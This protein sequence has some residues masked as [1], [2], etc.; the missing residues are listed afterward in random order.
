V[1]CNIGAIATDNIGNC[2]R[3]HKQLQQTTCENDNHYNCNIENDKVCNYNM[4][5]CNS[6]IATFAIATDEIA[7]YI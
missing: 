3:Q 1:S 7:T 4:V 6:S 2:N 5:N